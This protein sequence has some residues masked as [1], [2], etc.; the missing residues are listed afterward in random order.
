MCAELSRWPL[1]LCLFFVFSFRWRNGSVNFS[2]FRGAALK[3]VSPLGGPSPELAPLSRRQK[4]SYPPP[5][6][7]FMENKTYRE[8]ERALL[9]N[10]REAVNSR[11]EF[12]YLDAE[13]ARLAAQDMEVSHGSTAH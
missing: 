2:L 5:L 6:G 4:F 3:K 12:D 7:R 13:L 10:L 1:V 8:T 11:E 9:L